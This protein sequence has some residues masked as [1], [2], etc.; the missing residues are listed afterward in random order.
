MFFKKK[1]SK[2][3][4]DHCLSALA[5]AKD[6]PLNNVKVC[7]GVT[8]TILNSIFCDDISSYETF[9]KAFVMGYYS[10]DLSTG[11]KET[12]DTIFSHAF[13]KNN[14]ALTT[15]VKAQKL[16][17]EIGAV[18]QN[19]IIYAIAMY[20]SWEHR[21]PEIQNI[22]EFATKLPDTR[23]PNKTLEQHNKDMAENNPRAA[24]I[25][26][27]LS[28][29][30]SKKLANTVTAKMDYL[31]FTCEYDKEETEEELVN[32]I[33][34]EQKYNPLQSTKDSFRELSK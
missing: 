22:I 27:S 21:K 26:W 4:S 8:E 25:A 24:V 14:I 16:D 3:T 32:R 9:Y 6:I 29:V 30:K 5:G 19:A 10:G 7:S 28:A 1:S 34:D 11:N 12:I 31:L 13:G 23:Q 33:F 15:L 17:G 20:I 2:I 18:V